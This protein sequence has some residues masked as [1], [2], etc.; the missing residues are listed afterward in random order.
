MSTTEAKTDPA[1]GAVATF[2]EIKKGRATLVRT[3]LNDNTMKSI[4]RLLEDLEADEASFAWVSPNLM[5]GYVNLTP[6]IAQRVDSRISSY[7][8]VIQNYET[9]MR[10]IT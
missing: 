2:E 4:R 5:V 7:N 1:P 9:Y 6:S 10:P 3:D 8:S